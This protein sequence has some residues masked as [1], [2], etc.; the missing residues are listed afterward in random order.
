M[1]VFLRKRYG[2]FFNNR[3]NP[4][5]SIF[6]KLVLLIM[7]TCFFHVLGIMGPSH[8]LSTDTS[9]AASRF[10]WLISPKRHSVTMES[11][12]ELATDCICSRATGRT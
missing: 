5:V 10:S 8:Q 4:D 11:S 9:L 6:N 1:G 3:Y 2:D 7:E 12:F